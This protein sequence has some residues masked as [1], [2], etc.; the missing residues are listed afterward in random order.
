MSAPLEKIRKDLEALEKQ[1]ADN[2]MVV[3]AK[4]KSG[5][6]REMSVDEC[7]EN[8]ATFV[9]VVQGSNQADLDRLMCHEFDKVLSEYQ[10]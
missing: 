5:D 3:L 10:N 4:T 8:G 7:I 1:L 2:H 9:K 6:V